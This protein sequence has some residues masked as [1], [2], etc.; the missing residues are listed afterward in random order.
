MSDHCFTRVL[1]VGL[2]LVTLG[3]KAQQFGGNPPSIKWDQVNTPAARVIYP[4]GM[5]S[6]G[7]R[8]ANVIGQINNAIKPT[9][10]FRQKQV[11]VVLQNQ[12][13]TTNGY[14]GLAPFRSEFYLVPAQ[15]SFSL[16]S[17]NVTD[18]LAIHEFRHVQQYNS[19][20]V[21]LTRLLH[22]LFGEGGQQL[23]SGLSLPNWFFEGDA[24]FNET[25]VTE[26]GRG[27][28][29]Y[30]FN[31]FR[32]L[33]AANKDYSWMK[34]RNG[35]YRDYTPDW[36]PLGYMMVA[37]GR[38]QYG[39][40]IWRKVG[41][42]AASYRSLIYP[43]QSAVKRNTGRN[44]TSFR[45]AALEK[46]KTQLVDD[47]LKQGAAKYKKNQHFI[48]NQE[49]PVYVNDSTLIY[50]TSSYKQRS[51]FVMRTG[52]KEER[53]R[54]ADFSID[55]YFTCRNG[56]IV[57]ASRRPDARW[58]YREFNELKVIDVKSGAQKKI[59]NRTR[60]FAPAFNADNSRIVA[61]DVPTDGQYA[62]HILDADGKLISKVPNSEHLY[63]TYPKFYNEQQIVSAVRKPTGEMLLALIDIATG[64]I[65]PLTPATIAPKAFPVVQKDTIYFTGT[66][67]IDDKLFAVSVADRKLYE[68][69]GDSL[70]NF[71]GNYQPAVS[72]NKISWVS[73]S[74]FGFRLHEASKATLQPREVKA[75]LGLP[76]MQVASLQ[77]GEGV[78]AL[79]KI[80]DQPLPTSKYPKFTHP[81][82]FH[83]LIPYIE[84]PDY[85][86]SLMGQ[87]ILNT[88]Q[89]E[90]SFGY[91]RNEGYKQIGATMIYGAM[92]P[93]LFGGVQYTID[94]RDL[95]L[96]QNRNP[97]EVN[98]NET[99]LQAG[100]QLPLSFVNG[101]NIS[102]LNLSSSINYSITDVKQA[103]FRSLYPDNTYLSNSITFSNQVSKPQQ[104]IYPHFAQN[105][106]LSFR[107]TINDLSARQFLVSGSF[108]FPGLFDTHSLVIS[109]AHQ[110]RDRNYS[111]FSNQL[112]FSRG[113]TADNLYRLYKFGVNYHFPIA[114]PDAGFGDLVYLL[115][116]RGNVFYDHTH[117]IDQY[118][119][120]AQFKANFRSA[121]A[122]LYFDTQWFNETS[123]TFGLRY[124]RLLDRDIFGGSGPDRFTLIL[125]LSIF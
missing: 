95:R 3:V 68:L 59:T 9:I 88:L 85:L 72:D 91:N 120:G 39:S 33:W 89:S 81:F 96:D 52:T 44:F 20:D 55:S 77:H 15:N 58:G 30:F 116:L 8:V 19:T 119:S 29:P 50:R 37:Y 71:I 49:F 87:N 25:Y 125:P 110:R 27:R 67:G 92:F 10:G 112:S 7:R 123:I 111:I 5:D 53:I 32:S 14:V 6:A 4:R 17:L 79:N 42:D 34:I 80:T 36:Y 24:V 74:A 54:L 16:G 63:Y 121:G 2:L 108:Y 62:L 86:V 41:H 12:L 38:D 13:V 56:Q 98:W 66:S 115:R 23:A 101:R 28:L 69:E 65:E 11:N 73:F 122:E 82:N 18:Q 83:S 113:Y 45:N 94:R 75:P 48:G 100:L 93:Y 21:G 22:I 107:N 57:Y 31:G 84:D 90:L 106:T 35:S 109:A 46:F 114:Y 1:T 103:A 105:I 76:D 70:R 97:V 118:R 47:G 64:N 60:Y 43:F 124:T 117:G 26:Q 78:N 99:R 104:L 61:V 102:R 40:D 51:A